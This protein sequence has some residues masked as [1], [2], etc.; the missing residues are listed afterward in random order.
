MERKTHWTEN[1]VKIL[2]DVQALFEGDGTLT[3][4]EF[5]TAICEIADK[6]EVSERRILMMSEVKSM[7]VESISLPANTEVLEEKKEAPPEAKKKKVKKVVAEAKVEEKPAEVITE[8]EKPEEED[9]SVPLTESAMKMLRSV[10]K[11]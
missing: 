1:R 6:Y 8:T 9:I 2:E 5:I 7:I 10:L 3:E 11:L 4:D